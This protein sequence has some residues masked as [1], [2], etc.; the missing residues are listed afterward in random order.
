M[1]LQKAGY[2]DF[3][4][5]VFSCFLI[6]PVSADVKRMKLFMLNFY[7]VYGIIIKHKRLHDS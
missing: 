2:V 6:A 4:Y 3:P 7:M 1:S 5:P